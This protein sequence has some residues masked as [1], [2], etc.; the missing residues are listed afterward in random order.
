MHKLLKNSNTGTPE[1]FAQ[2]LGISRSCLYELIDEFKS[3]RAPIRYSKSAKTFY[4]TEPFEIVIKCNFQPLTYQEEK[5]YS[6][7]NISSKILFFRTIRGEISS[8]S[9][10]C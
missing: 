1:E 6:G 9:L 8:V 5:Q 3:R 2:Q 10:S 4:Y 7:G